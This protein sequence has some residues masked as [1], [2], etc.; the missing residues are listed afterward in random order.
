MSLTALVDLSEIQFPDR[1]PD[2]DLP[3]P[4]DD[5]GVLA[6]SEAATHRALAR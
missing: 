3:P 1:L 5:D 2:L 6:E 4:A